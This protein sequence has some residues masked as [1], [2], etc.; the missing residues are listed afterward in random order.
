LHADA[1]RFKP[2]INAMRGNGESVMAGQ[3]PPLADCVLHSSV[4]S[5][6]SVRNPPT[7]S[8]FWR[9]SPRPTVSGRSDHPLIEPNTTGYEVLDYVDRTGYVEE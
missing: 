6:P 7:L 3:R 4:I 8:C 9:Y 1:A 2:T 5:E